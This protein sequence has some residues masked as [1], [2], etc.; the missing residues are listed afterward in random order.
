[1][2]KATVMSP[3]RGIHPNDDHPETIMVKAE[4]I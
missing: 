3:E 2:I 1:M 4:I